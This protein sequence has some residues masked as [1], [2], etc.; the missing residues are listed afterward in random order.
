[1]INKQKL[2]Q[3]LLAPMLVLGISNLARADVVNVWGLGNYAGGVGIPINNF[4]DSLADH[5]STIITG[6][7]DSN[8]LTGVSL[9]WVIQPLIALTPAEISTLSDF[10]TTGGRIAFMGEHGSGLAIQENNNISAAVTALGGN[11]TILNN[12]ALDSGFHTATRVGGQ[13]LDHTLTIGVDTYEYAYYAPLLLISPPAQKLMLGTDLS[14]VM[15]AFENIGSGSIFMI[16][17]QNVVNFSGSVDND[18]MF[19][20]L[21]IGVTGAPPTI[22]AVPVEA[23]P[24]PTMS[25]WALIILSMLI[26]LMAFTN[27]SRLF[28]N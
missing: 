18:V 10:L 11:M 22:D 28:R 14:S 25:K 17:D 1:M 21:L 6:S 3:L 26:G 23:V 20:N 9:L 27:R 19:E 8:D 7:L 15:M 2:M 24:I 16:T 12:S 4:Y 5:S 13:I